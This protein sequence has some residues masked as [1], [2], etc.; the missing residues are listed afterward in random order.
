MHALLIL[1]LILPSIPLHALSAGVNILGTLP[2]LRR[3]LS[4]S[5]TEGLRK[6]TD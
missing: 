3:I 1:S 5:I 4:E 2:P 6:D